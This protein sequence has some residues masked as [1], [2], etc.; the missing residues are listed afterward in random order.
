MRQRR[1]HVVVN[2]RSTL[3][4]IFIPHH[5]IESMRCFHGA[6]IAGA[7]IKTRVHR[8][9]RLAV[10]AIANSQVLRRLRLTHRSA[11]LRDHLVVT[12]SQRSLCRCHCKYRTTDMAQTPSSQGMPCREPVQHSFVIPIRSKAYGSPRRTTSG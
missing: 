5:A 9:G 10:P 12:M 3:C 7:R 11:S 1:S 6:Q 4:K 2:R 8:F